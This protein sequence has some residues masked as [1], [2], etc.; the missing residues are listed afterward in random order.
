MFKSAAAQIPIPTGV[1]LTDRFSQDA[2]DDMLKDYGKI[3]VKD[4]ASAE[5]VS[6][7]EDAIVERTKSMSIM[8]SPLRAAR[9]D[10]VEFI[11][12]DCS[13]Y[14]SD[15]YPIVSPSALYAGQSMFKNIAINTRYGLK[16][17]AAIANINTYLVRRPTR[18]TPLSRYL[19]VSE[20]ER[21]ML[22]LEELEDVI[23]ITLENEEY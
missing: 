13:A 7:M 22:V 19:K 21:M 23:T 18:I 16:Y 15:K 20:G 11:R 10:V 2:Y 4:L 1:P 6:H 5:I 8:G 17:R 14:I 3:A 9:E 12:R